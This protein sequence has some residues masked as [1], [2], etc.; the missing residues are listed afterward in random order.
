MGRYCQSMMS[1]CMS[2]REVDLCWPQKLDYTKNFITGIG[3]N[4]LSS[5]SL[6]KFQRSSRFPKFITRFQIRV[7]KC[8]LFFVAL[9]R[10]NTGP[11]FLCVLAQKGHC[12]GSTA[13]SGRPHMSPLG[14]HTFLVVVAYYL[15]NLHMLC[16]EL[17]A[18][19]LKFIKLLCT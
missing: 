18:K 5:L 1:V 14:W 12:Q 13:L 10:T 15:D 3:N 8:C 17:N 4:T 19:L 11:W 9:D 6:R 16:V 2:V 7:V